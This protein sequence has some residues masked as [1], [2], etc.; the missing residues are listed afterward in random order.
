MSNRPTASNVA[1]SVPRDSQGRQR[2]KKWKDQNPNLAR[3]T[4]H[5]ASAK[6]VDEIV[7][8][9]QA[10]HAR[11]DEVPECE[12]LE[13]LGHDELVE[14]ALEMKEDGLAGHLTIS[15]RPVQ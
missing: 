6:T 2:A 10:C 11:G 7:A 5:T 12:E 8:M 15:H 9:L 1:G 13:H 3:L 4:E 14:L